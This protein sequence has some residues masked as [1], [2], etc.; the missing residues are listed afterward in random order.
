MFE[1][2]PRSCKQHKIC[3]Y[4][5]KDSCKTISDLSYLIQKRFFNND[6][7]GNVYLYLVGDF[8]FPPQ[9]TIDV[10]DANDTLIV[11]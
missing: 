10:I 9:E 3:F 11:K 6:G 5:N 4:L 2:N 7:D 1:S 8:Y